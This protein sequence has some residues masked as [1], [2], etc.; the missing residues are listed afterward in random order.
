[1]V[2]FDAV[3]MSLPGTSRQFVARHRVGSVVGGTADINGRVASAGLVEFNPSLHLA[4]NFA[5][6]HNA[7]LW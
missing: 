6:M 2:L 4:A 5:V 3:H 7:A 1:M